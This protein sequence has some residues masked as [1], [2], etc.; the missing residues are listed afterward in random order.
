MRRNDL[1]LHGTQY[2]LPCL[3]CRPQRNLLKMNETAYTV[4]STT[5]RTFWR[6]PHYFGL[7]SVFG[8]RNLKPAPETGFEKR[9]RFFEIPEGENDFKPSPELD[10]SENS[11]LPCGMKTDPDLLSD[12]EIRGAFL[13]L[14]ELGFTA[15]DYA[16]AEAAL[17]P[18]RTASDILE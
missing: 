8:L 9:P 2:Y 10:M 6:L 13:L 7:L 4:R 12:P 11:E 1:A 18:T 17:S 16:R 14:Y 3:P 5:Y 15:D